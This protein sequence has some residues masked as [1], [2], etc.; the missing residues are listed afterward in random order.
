MS[1]KKT[2]KKTVKKAVKKAAKKAVK[3]KATSKKTASKKPQKMR[4]LV[5][6]EDASCFWTTDGAVLE[7]LQQLETAFGS[8]EDEVFLHHVTKE[9]ND[10]ADWVEH[11][12]D[13]AACAADLRRSKKPSSARTVVKRHLRLYTI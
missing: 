7:D 5:C 9:K 13:D 1:A 3:K 4:A 2:T 10:F 6:A 8:M 12:L 11:V